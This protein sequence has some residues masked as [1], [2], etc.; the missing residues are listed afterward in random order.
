MCEH[1]I[2]CDGGGS[3]LVGQHV[4]T[5]RDLCGFFPIQFHEGQA[6]IGDHW[7]L[8]SNGVEMG[9]AWSDGKSRL[10]VRRDR[11]GGWGGPRGRG[12]GAKK[13]FPAPPWREASQPRYSPPPSA[14]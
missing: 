12:G 1:G 4:E 2:V 10:Q 14:R 9:D 7:K 8:R 13:V 3:S 5:V 11:R 6:S